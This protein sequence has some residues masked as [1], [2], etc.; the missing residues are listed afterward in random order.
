MTDSRRSHR[1]ANQ[2]QAELA[3]LIRDEV[4]D[5]R[6]GHATVTAVRLSRDLSHAR[7]FVHSSD[8]SVDQKRLL[9]GLASARGFLRTQLSHRLGH[10][11]RI[12]ELSFHYDTSM[13]AGIRVEE[14]LDQ[15]TDELEDKE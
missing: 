5:P 4:D 13:E 11:R 14:L 3:T 9:G 7:V 2:I 8:A 12:P 1:L 15:F 10:L 6:V